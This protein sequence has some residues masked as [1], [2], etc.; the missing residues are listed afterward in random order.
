MDSLLDWT[1]D[2]V[3]IIFRPRPKAFRQAAEH[4]DGKFNHG[5]LLVIL[6]A[7]IWILLAA[8]MGEAP[9]SLAL[10]LVAI[11]MVAFFSILVA[12]WFHFLYQKLFKQSQNLHSEIFYLLVLVSFFLG[13][14][15][16]L[17]RFAP[18][19]GPFLA[20]ALLL[21]LLILLVTGLTAIT[22]LNAVKSLVIVI[23]SLPLAGLSLILLATFVPSVMSSVQ[24]LF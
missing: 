2:A 4:A 24:Q 11:M 8:A 12:F 20:N 23:L 7:G 9:L 6:Q 3:S 13:T 5:V 17:I 15:A 22:G 1:N 18:F 19:I 21:Y 14:P 10:S 16:L